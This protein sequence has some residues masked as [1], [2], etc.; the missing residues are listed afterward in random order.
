MDVEIDGQSQ[1]VS[2]DNSFRELVP[3]LAPS[4]SSVEASAY[5]IKRPPAQW[6]GRSGDDQLGHRRDHP[7][8]S[9]GQPRILNSREERQRVVAAAVDGSASSAALVRAVGNGEIVVDPAYGQRRASDFVQVK[10]LAGT[11]MSRPQFV[12]QPAGAVVVAVDGQLKLVDAQNRVH[13]IQLP[14]GISSV[15]AFSIAPDA[16]RV[17]FVS[18]GRLYFSVIT[19]GDTPTMTTAQPIVIGP[20][21]ATATSVA[22]SSTYQLVVGGQ[23][24]STG[25][26]A[27][28]NV[29]G[30]LDPNPFTREYPSGHDRPGCGLLVRSAAAARLRRGHGADAAATGKQ[31]VI[32]GRTDGKPVNLTAPFFQ[33]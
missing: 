8:R 24:G 15:S 4:R 29:D 20:N 17:A 1:V 27:E 3:N 21:L 22:W 13:P 11:S 12:T 5:A 19:V 2:S 26:I 9:P 10:G 14:S 32:A 6:Q 16:H 18:G 23:D 25:K 33:D 30:S 7:R 28:L 31:E